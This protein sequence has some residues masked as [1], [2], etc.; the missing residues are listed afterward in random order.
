M[1]ILED[2]KNAIIE[3]E[4]DLAVELVGKAMSDGIPAMEIVSGGLIPG[5]GVVGEKFKSFEYFL[6]E[7]IVAANAFKDSFA[8]LLPA[9]DASGYEP[10][11]RILIGTVAGDNHDIG[12][13]IVIALLRGNGYEVEDAGVDVGPERFVE[14]VKERK[15][16][17]VGMSALLTTTMASMRETVVA[18]KSAGVRDGVKVIIGGSCVSDEFSKNIGADGYAEDAADAVT[19]VGALLGK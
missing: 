10:K 4:P 8:L 2:I 11:G 15:P 18:L 6:P 3:M 17:V 16:N 14:L 12:K 9:L 7:V 19:L 5:I 13:N 1:A